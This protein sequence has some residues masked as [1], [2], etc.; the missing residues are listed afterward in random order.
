MLSAECHRI[1]T[2]TLPL[3]ATTQTKQW[4]KVR[5]TE[6]RCGS[7]VRA[8][9]S[10]AASTQ[11]PAEAPAGA[12]APPSPPLFDDMELLVKVSVRSPPPVAAAAHGPDVWSSR[13][14][15]PPHMAQSF[16]YQRSARGQPLNVP[17]CKSSSAP[18]AGADEPRQ[19]RTEEQESAAAAAMP[20]SD[21]REAISD[22]Y[23][24]MW[25]LGFNGHDPLSLPQCF[26]G[27]AQPAA[28]AAAAAAVAAAGNAPNPYVAA[29]GARAS[30]A[31]TK[32]R[33]GPQTQL[34]S[35][36]A[37]ATGQRSSLFQRAQPQ[38]QLVDSDDDD[39]EDDAHA[40]AAGG[41]ASHFDQR[42][43]SDETDADWEK[44]FTHDHRDS[45]FDSSP[46]AHAALGLALMP[47]HSEDASAS[48][49]DDAAAAAAASGADSDDEFEGSE[50]SAKDTAAA[51]VDAAAADGLSNAAGGA[52]QG[53]RYSLSASSRS[54]SSPSLPHQQQQQRLVYPRVDFSY[55]L[56]WMR[57]YITEMEKLVFE[58]RNLIPDVRAHA[59]PDLHRLA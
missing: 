9:A 5:W 2:C 29:S 58:L 37:D 15:A 31:R 11:A 14:S 6:T 49:E 7:A 53:D 47:Q 4:L 25:Q 43:R 41:G 46:D 17:T 48:S 30:G 24:W 52:T 33:S 18:T 19:Q 16:L 51:A 50:A 21:Y 28:A 34:F 27:A 59:P 23:E 35:A 12:A 3:D 39:D 42:Q 56:T 32:D 36:V 13:E 38:S 22:G 45:V 20:L 8:A 55:P 26:P 57:S 1:G 44:F 40:G 54:L 10:S